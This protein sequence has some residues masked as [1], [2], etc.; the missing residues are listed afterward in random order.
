MLFGASGIHFVL[1]DVSEHTG[2]IFK[3]QECINVG[4][5]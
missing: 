1:T 4:K 2:H 5:K 3:G